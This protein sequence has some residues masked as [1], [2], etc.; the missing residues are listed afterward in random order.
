[1]G[2]LM[3]IIHPILRQHGW[4]SGHY[5]KWNK[6]KKDKYH[7][8]SLV[9]GLSKCG[10]CRNREISGCQELGD[11]GNGAML[12]KGYKHL[13]IRWKSSGNL[14]NLIKGWHTGCPPA[15]T[16]AQADSPLGKP[17]LSTSFSPRCP[18]A[19]LWQPPGIQRE[20]A[21]SCHNPCTGVILRGEVL[22]FIQIIVVLTWCHFTHS[23]NL[24]ALNV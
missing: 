2:W 20:E 11:E 16:V 14:T 10:A 19:G 9:C 23:T 6:S 21:C 17:L 24:N 18:S 15:G 8:I 13:I 7:V 1:M 22:F 5:V 3:D 4:I 12:V